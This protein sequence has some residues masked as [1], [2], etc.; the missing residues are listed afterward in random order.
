VVLNNTTKKNT[1]GCAKTLSEASWL[2]ITEYLPHSSE[3]F[4]SHFRCCCQ[5]GT[6]DLAEVGL[7]L[8][9]TLKTC[10]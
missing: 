5:Q 1:L 10:V 2:S 4:H 3:V 9:P 7:K 6:S 8:L